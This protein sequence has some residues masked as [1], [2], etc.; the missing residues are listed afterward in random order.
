MRLH[1]L[2]AFAKPIA[3]AASLVCTFAIAQDAA[4]KPAE[5]SKPVE[6]PTLTPREKA[7]QYALRDAHNAER[8]KNDKPPLS[9]APLLVKAAYEHAKDMA[10]HQEMTHTGSDGTSADQRV[11]RAGYKFLGTGENV[12]AGHT[13]I[14]H[15][16]RDWMTSEGH[17]ANILGDFTEIGGA[18]V[19]G[20][21]GIHYWAVEFG[22]PVPDVVPSDL[23]S[24]YIQALNEARKAK[25]LAPLSENAVL[26]DIAGSIARDLAKPHAVPVNYTDI[27]QHIKDAGYDYGLISLSIGTVHFDPKALV[28][29]MVDADAAQKTVLGPMQHAGVGVATDEKGIPHWVILLGSL[30]KLAPPAQATKADRA[31]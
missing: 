9:V 18:R 11:N 10:K 21:D 15:A 31:E 26:R 27:Y 7:F 12:A 13:T 19:I 3:V 17:R 14:A 20:K 22:K 28:K 5:D 16:V 6:V 29:E 30:E 2:S 23:A 24:A 1:A 8:K 25:K 4:Q